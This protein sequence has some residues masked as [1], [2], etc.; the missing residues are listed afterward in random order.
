MQQSVGVLL[1]RF[2]GSIRCSEGNRTS[3]AVKGLRQRLTTFV[4]RGFAVL[5]RASRD[6]RPLLAPLRAACSCGGGVAQSSLTLAPPAVK[7]A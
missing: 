5:D 2:S 1:P 4:S 7:G 3:G 6:I